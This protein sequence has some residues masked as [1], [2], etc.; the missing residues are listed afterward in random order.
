M[1]FAIPLVSKSQITRVPSKQP[2]ANSVPEGLKEATHDIP[3]LSV[4]SITSGKVLLKGSSI[5]RRFFFQ[6]RIEFILQ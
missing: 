1:V 2:T 4:A 3:S 5:L 6:M